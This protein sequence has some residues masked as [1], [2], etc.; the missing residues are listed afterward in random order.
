MIET[1]RLLLRK[2]V[3]EDGLAALDLIGDPVA[4]EFLG[5]VHPRAAADPS[6][7]VLEG[8][9]SAGLRVGEDLVEQVGPVAPEVELEQRAIALQPR[10]A[11]DSLA[12]L[13]DADRPLVLASLVLA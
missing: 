11:D 6:F 2:P 1:P 10:P 5:G 13:P 3:Y 9:R 4:M 7:V 8:D 12:V